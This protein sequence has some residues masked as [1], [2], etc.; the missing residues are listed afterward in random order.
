MNSEFWPGK[1]VFIT[2]HTGFKGSWLA[3]W[4]HSLGAEVTGY[5]LGTPT[6]PSLYEEV[7]LDLLID[8]NIGDIRDQQLLSSV[9]IKAQPEIVIHMAAQPLV[10]DSYELPVE[11]YSTNIMGTINVFEAVRNINSVRVVVNVT[12]DKCYDNKEWMWGYRENEPLGGY[13]PYSSSKACAELITSAYRNS[14]F[15][16][17][18]FQEHG[19]A[20]ASVRAGNVIGGGDWAK[21]RL[22]PDCIRAISTGKAV[23]IRNP[24]SIRPWQHVLDPLHGYLLLAERLYEQPVKYSEAWNFGPDEY[25]SL[26]VELLVEKICSIWGESASYEIDDSSQPHEAHYLKLDCSKAKFKLGWHP[27]FLLDEALAKTIEWYRD[28]Y[29]GKN[30]RDVCFEQIKDFNGLK[31]ISEN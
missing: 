16:L 12:S 5:S 7:G 10:R 15:N 28:F 30:M 25:S 6:K 31:S 1:K 29:Q 8:S 26:P 13:D 22:I 27:K 18:R 20:L 19:V 3:L 4:L 24:S 14:F 9:M 11:T 23:V 21:D 2:G 17:G